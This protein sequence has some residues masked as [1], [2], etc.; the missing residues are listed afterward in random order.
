LTGKM[1]DQ[2]PVNEQR[3]LA[4][5][6]FTSVAQSGAP[7]DA[8]RDLSIDGRRVHYETIVLPL[9]SDGTAIDMLLIGLIHSAQP[10]DPPEPRLQRGAG[11]LFAGDVV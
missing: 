8:H 11:D 6:S 9:S 2:L 10:D 3:D 7:L 1:L 4:R 5:Q